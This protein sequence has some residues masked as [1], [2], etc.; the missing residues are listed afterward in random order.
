MLSPSRERRKFKTKLREGIVVLTRIAWAAIP[1][2]QIKVF[3]TTSD[4]ERGISAPRFLHVYV[5]PSWCQGGIDI[6]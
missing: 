5:C 3:P 4:F 6:K 1:H 2:P